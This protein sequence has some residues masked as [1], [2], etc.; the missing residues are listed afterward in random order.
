MKINIIS[1]TELEKFCDF[2]N[3]I[4]DKENVKK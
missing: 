2:E 1:E 4:L 3:F